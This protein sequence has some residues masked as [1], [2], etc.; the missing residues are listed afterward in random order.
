ML[1]SF[2]FATFS[3]SAVLFQN[4]AHKR[5]EYI[6]NFYYNYYMNIILTY[7]SKYGNIILG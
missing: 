2:Y 6:V 5:T 1:L 7:L 3:E 4:I